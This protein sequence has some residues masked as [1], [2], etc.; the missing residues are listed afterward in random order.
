VER[1]ARSRW[2]RDVTHGPRPAVAVARRE[3]MRSLD[4][5]QNS[6]LRAAQAVRSSIGM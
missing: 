3:R 6:R 2:L 1:A 5:A 4:P